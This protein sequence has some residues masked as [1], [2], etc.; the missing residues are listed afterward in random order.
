MA[1]NA[2]PKFAT[3]GSPPVLDAMSSATV[4][5]CA[6]ILNFPIR[7]AEIKSPSAA[8][9][10]LRPETA[11]S[12]PTMM[13]TAH[14]G[15]SRFSTSEMSAALMRSLAAAA[16]DLPVEVVGEGR[17][18]E[19]RDAE[20]VALD[21]EPVLGERR[22]QDDDEQ[23]HDEDA[24]QRQCVRKIKHAPSCPLSSRA[25]RLAGFSTR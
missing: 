2:R 16:G 23:G 24:R 21:A 19:E 5:T 3:G 8:A 22:E 20:D 9:I 13:Q 1:G 15:A 12:R 7:D 10:D 14:A 17:A 11:N 6:A 4:A 18:E 25:F